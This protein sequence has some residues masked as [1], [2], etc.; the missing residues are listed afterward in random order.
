MKDL[1]PYQPQVI[2]LC[3]KLL[4]ET[5]AIEHRKA[6]LG[7]AENY[8]GENMSTPICAALMCR[9]PKTNMGNESWP[10]MEKLITG[11]FYIALTA[12]MMNQD[13]K[14]AFLN[15]ALELCKNY[16]SLKS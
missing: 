16:A 6:G 13:D 5:K 3:D 7:N 14:D 11:W 4:N 9:N 12:G 1:T 15:T 10:E 2:A 8:N